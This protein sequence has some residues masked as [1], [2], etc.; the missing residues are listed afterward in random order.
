MLKSQAQAEGAEQ[1]QHSYGNVF[2]DLFHLT[3]SCN[4]QYIIS[5]VKKQ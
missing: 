3:T 4:V 1:G 2:D 5:K